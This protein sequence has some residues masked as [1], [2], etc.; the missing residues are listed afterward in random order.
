MNRLFSTLALAVIAVASAA[1]ALFAAERAVE[2]RIGGL[3]ALADLVVPDN[4]SIGN[5]VVLI[6]HGTLAHKDME[7]VEALQGALAERGVASLAPTLTLGIDRRTGMYDCKAPHTHAH[8]DALD[9]IGAW[10]GWLK[11]QG[12]GT[13][14][15]LGHSRGGNQTAW[16]AAERAQAGIEK[17]VLLAPTTEK[18]AT[19]TAEAYRERYKADL[20]GILEK[21]RKLAASGKGDQQIDLS[22]FIYCPDTK[23]TAASVLSYYG[24]ETK[25]DTPSLMSRIKLPVLVIAGSADTVVPDVAKRMKSHVDGARIKLEVIEGAGHMFLDFYAEDAADLIAGFMKQGS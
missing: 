2:L 22:G 6:T 13:L 19:N 17:I 24:A 14:T 1:S 8:K 4:G 20:G 23:A 11:E 21:A 5:G 16:F 15:L 9:E 18:G 7:L 3:T 25:R 12:A 10:T